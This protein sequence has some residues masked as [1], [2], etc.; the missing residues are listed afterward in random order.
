MEKQRKPEDNLKKIKKL[1]DSICDSIS[2]VASSDASNDSLNHDT[3]TTDSTA[4]LSIIQEF[5]LG[6]LDTLSG[7]EDVIDE[8]GTRLWNKAQE[9]KVPLQKQ[10]QPSSIDRSVLI[11]N[12]RFA[13]F[14]MIK[15]ACREIKT[16]Q[17]HLKLLQLSLKTGESMISAQMCERFEV[18][19]SFAVEWSKSLAEEVDATLWMKDNSS[20]AFATI[21]NIGTYY[22]SSNITRKELEEVMRVFISCAKTSKNMK[23]GLRW[24]E[25]ARTI[26][27]LNRLKDDPY[28]VESLADICGS[29]ACVCQNL[30]IFDK[31]LQSVNSGIERKKFL[32]LFL[33]K[34]QILRDGK[35]PTTLREEN[36][37]DALEVCEINGDSSLKIL[38]TVISHIDT[39]ISKVQAKNSLGWN[40]KN[41][42]EKVV[43]FKLVVITEQA[44]AF[45][46]GQTVLVMAEKVTD[47]LVSM[48]LG[49]E[50]IG[51]CQLI[52]WNTGTKAQ[53]NLAY[54]DAIQWYQLSLKFNTQADTNNFAILKR[55]ISSC[56]YELRDFE[57]ARAWIKEAETIS[58]SLETCLVKLLIEIETDN[59]NEALTDVAKIGEMIETTAITFAKILG[60]LAIATEIA[61]KKGNKRVLA[62]VLKCLLKVENESS[63]KKEVKQCVLIPAKILNIRCLS[64]ITAAATTQE[65][66]AEFNGLL[67]NFYAALKEWKN[68][69]ETPQQS[70]EIPAVLNRKNFIN[71]S[72]W[73]FETAWNK[74][75]QIMREKSTENSREKESMV[76]ELLEIVIDGVELVENEIAEILILKKLCRFIR[77]NSFLIMVRQD[78]DDAAETLLRNAESELIEF[79]KLRGSVDDVVGANAMDL[80]GDNIDLN[81]TINLKSVI[82]NP[83]SVTSQSWVLEFEIYLRLKKFDEAI[84][85][86]QRCEETNAEIELLQRM[87][88]ITTRISTPSGVQFVTYRTALDMTLKQQSL[89][90]K[91]FSQWF[92]ILITVSLVSN[93]SVSLNLFKQALDIIQSKQDYPEEEIMWL[94]ITCWNNGC[95]FFSAQ[96]KENAKIWCELAL[97]LVSNIATN[98]QIEEMRNA[99]SEILFTT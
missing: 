85:I 53:E 25:N 71:E 17:A 8:L 94:G 79:Q 88:D 69:I 2:K 35:F 82:S 92:R 9:I 4:I 30:K 29:M 58:K 54:M 3:I 12:V 44:G 93:K 52:L 47:A 31:A 21:S 72:C 14:H 63:D 37:S 55:K 19:W 39:L 5:S 15:F 22:Q 20:V 26:A 48:D 18:L 56:Y 36:V 89:S 13:A 84:E 86:V 6:A 51:A 91:S 46:G 16:P 68:F 97:S 59:Q 34:S 32:S 77:C 76:I 73:L 40:Q 67:Q 10:I 49:Q 33:L 60:V 83:E 23:D 90:M 7:S 74:A 96:D 28:F 41:L 62:A 45:G 61:Y 81:E 38:P 24:F 57:K 11:A 43:L 1:T 65:S 98:P 75:L 70:S 64:R 50:T 95:D 78:K 87:C 27:Q 80:D 66:L 42:I 99:F